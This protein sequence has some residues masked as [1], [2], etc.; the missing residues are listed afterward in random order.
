MNWKMCRRLHRWLDVF[1]TCS[2]G[3]GSLRWK[4]T[5]N[6]CSPFALS[7]HRFLPL[8]PHAPHL[9]LQKSEMNDSYLPRLT[10]PGR[11]IL[12]QCPEMEKN[13]AEDIMA[14]SACEVL[15]FDTESK[16]IFYTLYQSP[17]RPNQPVSVIQLSSQDTCIVW[18]LKW[19]NYD[20]CFPPRLRRILQS[21]NIVKVQW[22]NG[23]CYFQL[24]FSAIL[25]CCCS[26]CVRWVMLPPEMLS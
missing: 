25:K 21:K 20:Y 26:C 4:L 9:D 12:I 23:A 7:F 3:S 17:K 16:P 22:T 24:I 10:F 13:Y 15:G 5:C 11:S 19:H 8:S 2:R 6:L 18:Q 14:L 1:S